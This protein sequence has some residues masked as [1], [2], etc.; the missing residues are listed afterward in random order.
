MVV[1]VVMVVTRIARIARIAILVVRIDVCWPARVRRGRK[2]GVSLAPP[3][4][5]RTTASN[6]MTMILPH[7]A[8]GFES[9]KLSWA[10]VSI[11]PV[12]AIVVDTAAAIVV[13][14]PPTE[15][16]SSATAVVGPARS[17]NKPSLLRAKDQYQR[18][19]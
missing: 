5:P 6:P 12:V 19:E 2:N 14:D 10:A 7:G 16:P 15:P 8:R 1:M 4:L 9:S 3:T 18:L 11:D 17:S 13:G